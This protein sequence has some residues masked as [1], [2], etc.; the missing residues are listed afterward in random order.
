[1]SLVS[2][3]WLFNNRENVKIIDCSWH[4]PNEKRNS[5]EEYNSEH[6]PNAIYF[7]IDKNSDLNLIRLICF[8]INIWEKNNVIKW[9]FNNDK[10]VIYDNSK[11]LSSCRLW[12][13][14]LYFGHSKKIRY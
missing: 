6:I 12:Y 13:M 3:K 1:M 2:T 9:N 4:L 7:D 5:L 8:L 11:V 14:L 10:I